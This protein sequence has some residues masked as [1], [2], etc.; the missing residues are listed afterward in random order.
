MRRI[1]DIQD[2]KDFIDSQ[3]P[4]TKIYIGT[5]SYRFRK[6]NLW[7][8]RYTTAVVVH[9]DGKHGCSVWGKIIEEVDYD[10]KKSEPKMR[11]MNEVYK[12]ADMYLQLADVIEDREIEVHIDVNTN[13]KY[14]SS[15]VLQE[16]IGYI[17]GVCNVVPLAKP[18]AWAASFAADRFRE[19]GKNTA[20]R[21]NRKKKVA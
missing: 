14:G 20:K 1:D 15:V 4:E 2:L 16:A 6:D 18:D 17:R 21:K 10:K 9:I 8:A 12:T 13:R 11:L 19:F 3:S 5:D 7:I